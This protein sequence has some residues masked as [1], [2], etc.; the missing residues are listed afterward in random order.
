MPLITDLIIKK[1]ATAKFK[2]KEYRPWDI[3]ISSAEEEKLIPDQ[4]HSSEVQSIT[5]EQ[6]DKKTNLSDVIFSSFNLEKEWRNLYG[7]KK[8]VFICL[9]KRIDE[10]DDSKVITKNIT[11]DQLATELNLPPNTIKGALHQLKKSNLLYTEETKPG[12]GGYARYRILK[13]VF[14]FFETKIKNI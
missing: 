11:L 3:S 4:V 13:S 14:S 9:I 12:R 7:A 8:E 10:S 5:Q 2:K 1:E 6:V